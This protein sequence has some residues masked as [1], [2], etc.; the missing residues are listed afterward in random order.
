MSIFLSLSPVRFHVHDVDDDHTGR[1]T[2]APTGVGSTVPASAG[3]GAT[4]VGTGTGVGVGPTKTTIV[5]SA[6]PARF[7]AEALIKLRSAPFLAAVTFY[8]ML[9]MFGWFV[10]QVVLVSLRDEPVAQA[11]AGNDP[12]GYL[13]VLTGPLGSLIVDF[14]YSYGHE[15]VNTLLALAT[16]WA[17][18]IHKTRQLR[19]TALFATT[20]VVFSWLVYTRYIFQ[21]LDKGWEYCNSDEFDYKF[22]RISMANGAW[23]VLTEIGMFVA[24]CWAVWMFFTTKGLEP[25]NELDKK[26]LQA[27]A[28][29][30][31]R[32]EEERRRRQLSSHASADVVSTVPLGVAAAAAPAHK[33]IVNLNE[34]RLDTLGRIVLFFSVLSTIGFILSMLGN[35]EVQKLGNW[36]GFY[37]GSQTRPTQLI[38]TGPLTASGPQFVGFPTVFLNPT[39]F[40]QT[41]AP[42][43]SLPAAIP[44]GDLNYSINEVFT[45]LLLFFAIG[46][47]VAA[48]YDRV[49]ETTINPIMLT[50][51]STMAMFG[52]FIYAARRI[53][54]GENQESIH[55]AFG[56]QVLIVVGLAITSFSEA[57]RLL[58]LIAKAAK[59]P[60]G[61]EV[62]PLLSIS[63]KIFS[64]LYTIIL[65]CQFITLFAYFLVLLALQSEESLFSY[66]PVT[67]FIAA[68]APAAVQAQLTALNLPVT[69]TYIVT[70]QNPRSTYLLG[71]QTA[72]DALV[73]PYQMFVISLLICGWSLGMN[74]LS[75]LR[76]D[77]VG[78]LVSFTTLVVQAASWWLMC[79]PIVHATAIEDGQLYQIFCRKDAAGDYVFT[80]NICDEVAATG[81][82]GLIFFLFLIL[83]VII[84][85]FRWLLTSRHTPLMEQRVAA[86]A[87]E[88]LN[89]RRA[90]GENI[91]LTN[92]E[93]VLLM[94]EQKPNHS[95]AMGFFLF[96]TVAGWVIYAAASSKQAQYGYFL[97]APSQFYT[98]LRFDLYQFVACH[99]LAVSM[100]VTTFIHAILAT[101]PTFRHFHYFWRFAEFVGTAFNLILAIP[102]LI[103]MARVL[104]ANDCSTAQT[105][106]FSGFAIMVAGNFLNCLYC[107][108]LFRRYPLF[109]TPNDYQQF[110]RRTYA[111]EQEML[112]RKGDNRV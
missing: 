32:T 36:S 35:I 20:W 91:P 74:F 102:V 2:Y 19:A 42:A 25:Y 40:V 111:Q 29:D 88:N 62:A 54:L 14:Y 87:A 41:A 83:N 55:P 33:R 22:C 60:R 16:C 51:F 76:D 95:R 67:A 90:E 50:F 56:S 17:A 70:S 106:M 59:S 100:I 103:Y 37:H 26:D 18:V 44:V 27:A 4:T 38:S 24:W 10:T 48:A 39:T 46:L 34:C 57:I 80:E 105:A 1:T 12:T 78:N 73:F 89:K 65:V 5:N 30:A 53:D 11:R 104:N 108:S 43:Y 96:L 68:L 13:Q 82:L 112:A 71:Q 81:R 58:F 21:A 31:A 84:Q 99:F 6:G 9:M 85:L 63:R 23:S 3:V 64:A 79:F 45:A 110:S 15:A 28:R 69:S 61:E 94:E 75:K 109:T 47:S 66:T 7:P 107:Q 8:I 101:H 77:R 93:A 72:E 86:V 92:N 49:R 98:S 97:P 52:Y